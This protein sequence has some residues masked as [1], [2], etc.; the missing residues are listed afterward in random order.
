MQNFESVHEQN[1]ES[2]HKKNFPLHWEFEKLHYEFDVATKELQECGKKRSGENLVYN[3]IDPNILKVIERKEREKRKKANARVKKARDELISFNE[4]NR[5]FITLLTIFVNIKNSIKENDDRENLRK[6]IANWHTSLKE[7]KENLRKSIANW[8]TSLKEEKEN[9]RTASFGR[10]FIE[11]L[12]EYM[13]KVY[14]SLMNMMS[15][16]YNVIGDD[17]VRYSKSDYLQ[18]LYIAESLLPEFYSF[19][20]ERTNMFAYKKL[21]KLETADEL[22]KKSVF[23]IDLIGKIKLLESA[24]KLYREAAQIG[25]P[26]GQAF[27]LL[28][29][30]ETDKMIA[31]FKH[32][33]M[34]RTNLFKSYKV[35][36]NRL[37]DKIDNCK[38]LYV[39]S[40]FI[41]LLE[42]DMLKEN[43][44]NA[45]FLKS[46]VEI[47]RKA[48]LLKFVQR[49][50]QMSKVSKKMSII[51]VFPLPT[52]P[53]MYSPFIGF[54]LNQDLDR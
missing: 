3:C 28:D 49:I 42:D 35:F 10:R 34:W 5:L 16:L 27:V 12:E 38:F 36:L 26:Y 29:S 33:I 46:I 7:E 13:P 19:L 37:Y 22:Y 52:S 40:V 31:M 47:Y 9:M 8:H 30:N 1:F 21:K 24:N 44:M 14:N 15:P 54:L 2:V 51:C 6:S 11:Y 45:D 32:H 17:S 4:T 48:Y 39:D 41:N 43:V 18:R 53:L 25:D 50:V 23:T 20:Y